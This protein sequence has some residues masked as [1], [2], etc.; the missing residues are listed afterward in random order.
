MPLTLP[1]Y[2]TVSSRHLVLDVIHPGRSLLKMRNNN[3]PGTVRPSEAHRSLPSP[4]LISWCWTVQYDL[5]WSV[6]TEGL[7]PSISCFS[8]AI[9]SKFVNV[10]LYRRL[11]RILGRSNL[12]FL[13]PWILLVRGPKLL[14]VFHSSVYHVGRQLVCCGFQMISHAVGLNILQ[15][16]LKYVNDSGLYWWL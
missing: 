9:K 13:Y 5:L 1:L 4:S 16:T 12:V 15:F 3:G 10:E 11:P 14:A 8:D 6:S 7:Y 2:T